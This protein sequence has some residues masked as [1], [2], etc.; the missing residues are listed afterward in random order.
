MHYTGAE[1]QTGHPEKKRRQN[2]CFW[3][4]NKMQGVQNIYEKEM[5]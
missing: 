4:W 3:A 1:K 2:L 5:H